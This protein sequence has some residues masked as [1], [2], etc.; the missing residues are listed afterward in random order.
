[1]AAEP[2]S[3]EQLYDL[4]QPDPEH[5]LG[6]IKDDIEPD[7]PSVIGHIGALAPLRSAALCCS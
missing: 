2:V 7:H 6:G 5:T 3:P 1:M 4:A